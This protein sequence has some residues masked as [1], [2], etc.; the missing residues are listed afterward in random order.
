MGCGQWSYG[1][2]SL[3]GAEVGEVGLAP[4]NS[5]KK[6]TVSFCLHVSL[7]KAGGFLGAKSSS[8]FQNRLADPAQLRQV[9]GHSS[10]SLGSG[11]ALHLSPSG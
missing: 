3:Q 4:Y 6:P 1:L 9:W 8:R 10:G 7:E 5:P 2:G 11:P